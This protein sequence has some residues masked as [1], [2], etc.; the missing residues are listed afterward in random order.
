MIQSKT[1]FF[2]TLM[3]LFLGSCAFTEEDF[4]A[5]LEYCYEEHGP[6]APENLSEMVFKRGDQGPLHQ[7]ISEKPLWVRVSYY[8]PDIPPED[9]LLLEL[10]TAN[11]DSV[12][13]FQVSGDSL[14]AAFHTGEALPFHT[15]PVPSSH[16]IFYF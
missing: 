12:S 14:L 5:T 1:F 3:T 11:L 4:T 6:V 13:F 15:R 10:L 16:F 8:K 7:G 9:R 2:L